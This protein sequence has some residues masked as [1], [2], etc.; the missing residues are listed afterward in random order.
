METVKDLALWIGGS[1]FGF[2]VAYWWFRMTQFRRQFLF[3]M[4]DIEAL[5]QADR[6]AEAQERHR[7]LVL[8]HVQYR[9]TNN[10]R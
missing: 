4:R 6:L 8:E 7:S 10:E 1:A 5:I 2:V 9:E 3:S